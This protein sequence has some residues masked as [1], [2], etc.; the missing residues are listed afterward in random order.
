MHLFL[1]NP[2]AVINDFKINPPGKLINV[3]DD[4]Y[5]C[6]TTVFET[7]TETILAKVAE[8]LGQM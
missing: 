7:V 8:N 4:G 5:S 3:S 6:F 1:I 2:R